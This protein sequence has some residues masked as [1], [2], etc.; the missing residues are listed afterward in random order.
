L[1]NLDP[2]LRIDRGEN[3]RD[4]V[5]LRG[6]RERRGVVDHHRGL[7][8]VYV[9]QLRWLVIDQEEDAIFRRQKPV[10]ADFRE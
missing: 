7:V 8:T 9:G 1:K 5:R 6:L 3:R 2:A 10:E 4:S